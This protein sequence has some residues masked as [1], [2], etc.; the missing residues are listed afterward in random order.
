MTLTLPITN[1]ING[2]KKWQMFCGTRHKRRSSLYLFTNDPG[3]S[4]FH[5]SLC[6]NWSHT[7]RCFFAGFSASAVARII[8]SECK[9]VITSDGGYRGNKTIAL[10]EI[11]DEALEKCTSIEKVL[12][13]K[14]KH[15]ITMKEGRDIWLQPLLDGASDNSVAEIMDSRSS[16]HSISRFGK[17]ERFWLYG[18]YRLYF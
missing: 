14:N 13:V 8:D 11:I 10:K 5:F 7:F 18:L 1:C 4:C 16:I 17:T 2:F 3:I 12:V 6:E 9:M 15:S